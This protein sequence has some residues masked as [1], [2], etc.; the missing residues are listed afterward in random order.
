MLLVLNAKEKEKQTNL[1]IK[2]DICT[3]IT[4]I[5]FWAGAPDVCLYENFQKLSLKYIYE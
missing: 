2:G 1:T 4:Y 5:L 3:F